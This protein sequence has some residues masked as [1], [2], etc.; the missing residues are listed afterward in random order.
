M[1]AEAPFFLSIAALSASLAGLAGLVAA[2]RRGEGLS[3]NDRFRLH[4]IVEFSFAN[5]IIAISVIPL[6]SL[7]GSVET[8]VRIGGVAAFAYLVVNT[9][10][11][12]RR[13]RRMAIQLKQEWVVF[14]ALLDLAALVLAG[15]TVVTGSVG[16][17]QALLVVLLSRPMIAFLFVLSSFEAGGERRPD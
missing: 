3:T 11:L 10:L 12:G 7:T 5:I 16:S 2:L 13:A 1:T 9:L 8:A 15:A 14:V 6:T 4:E 17:F